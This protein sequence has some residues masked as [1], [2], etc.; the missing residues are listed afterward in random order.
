MDNNSY[1]IQNYE[2]VCLIV[3]IMINK[4]IL[5]IPYHI[6]SLVGTGSGVNVIYVGIIDLIFVLILNKLLKKFQNSDILDISEYLGGKTFKLVIGIFFIIFFFF[7][8][9]ITLIDFCKMLQII[10]FN[11]FSIIYITLFFIIAAGVIN[12]IGFKSIIRTACLIVPFALIS[13]LVSFFGGFEKFSF[14]NFVPFF[15]YNY[16]TT[17]ITGSINIYSMY[18]IAYFYFLTPLL[19]DSI[20]LKKITIISYSICWILLFLTIISILT[21]FPITNGT[22]SINTLYLLSRKIEVGTYIQRV[23]T[24]FILV[25]IM[26]IFSYLSITIF[27]INRII[28]KMT[29]I[30]DEKIITFSTCSILFGIGLLPLN[31]SAITFLERDLYKYIVIGIVFILSFLIVVFANMKFR[32][33]KGIKHTI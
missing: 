2:A 24:L 10:Y 20:N 23:D 17:F 12:L 13:I 11:N 25:W 1:K 19:K 33:K 9:F 4:L 3:I 22:Q 26:C 21:L 8:S 16:R 27:F 18:I 28:R 29:N 6:S 31:V 5:N 7:V 14:E 32:V 15:G 30:L